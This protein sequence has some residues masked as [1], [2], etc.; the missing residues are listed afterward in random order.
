MVMI[1]KQINKNLG[2]RV[3][4]S[5]TRDSGLERRGEKGGGNKEKKA[6]FSAIR[7]GKHS[8]K[9]L[10]SL[11]RDEK[12]NWSPK[13]FV[14]LEGYVLSVYVGGGEGNFCLT[15]LRS[16]FGGIWESTCGR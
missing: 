11:C 13:L 15:W 12:R 1:A 9:S 14:A 8:G 4:K 3:D 5:L 7:P 10:S 6:S 16:G 2:L